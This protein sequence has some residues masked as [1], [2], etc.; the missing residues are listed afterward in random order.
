MGVHVEDSHPVCSAR[1]RRRYWIAGYATDAACRTAIGIARNQ[2]EDQWAIPCADATELANGTT[3]LGKAICVSSLG[4]Q[5]CHRVEIGYAKAKALAP[6][7]FH[8][9]LDP[10][11]VESA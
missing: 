9:R 8:K 3:K 5:S 1:L 7:R 4:E 2:I 10:R 11:E 6:M